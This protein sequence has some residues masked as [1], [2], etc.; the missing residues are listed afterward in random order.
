MSWR[1]TAWWSVRR[2]QSEMGIRQKAIGRCEQDSRLRALDTGTKSRSRH[3]SARLSES[4]NERLRASRLRNVP[5]TGLGDVT[6]SYKSASRLF[7]GGIHTRGLR[8]TTSV[9]RFT[10]VRRPRRVP[11][12]QAPL[13]TVSE[14][15]LCHLISFSLV[16]TV[17]D[18]PCAATASRWRKC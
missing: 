17:L 6:I 4:A 15:I 7:S 12:V 9:S 14:C 1:R 11:P 16:W 13:Q 8:L 10:A 3:D 5:M 18:S 2:P